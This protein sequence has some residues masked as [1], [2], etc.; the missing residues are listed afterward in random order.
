[1]RCEAA[2]QITSFTSGLLNS[3]PVSSGSSTTEKSEKVTTSVGGEDA[4][5]KEVEKDVIVG[6]LEDRIALGDAESFITQRLLPAMVSLNSDSNIHV[7]VKLGQAIL[8]LAPLL[9]RELTV[10][11]LLPL[12]L[13]QLKDESPDVRLGVITSLYLVN[14]VVGVEEVSASLLP[15]IVDLAKVPVWRIRLAVIN[16][17][18][19]LADQLGETFF[20]ARLMEYFLS[21]LADAAY[22][23][24]EA[25]VLNLTRLTQKFG[26][27]WARTF[28]LSQVITF[29]IHHLPNPFVF[30]LIAYAFNFR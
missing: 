26:S 11:H 13:A 23:V 12:I 7:K 29:S 14:S 1:M 19:L 27:A 22:A 16:Q 3:Q 30:F 10:A 5:S 17:M 9:G 8:G 6:Q 2:S 18:P 20:E 24:R 25:A 15:A 4:I 21:W 28:F